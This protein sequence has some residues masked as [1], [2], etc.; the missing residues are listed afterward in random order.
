M[1][2]CRS[3]MAVVTPPGSGVSRRAAPRLS[4]STKT[5]LWGA[6]TPAFATPGGRLRFRATDVVAYAQQ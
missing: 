3:Q 2:C 1:D 5:L 4:I 6:L